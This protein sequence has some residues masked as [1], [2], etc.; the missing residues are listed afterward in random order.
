MILMPCRRLAFSHC[1]DSFFASFFDEYLRWLS[2][3]FEAFHFF[4]FFFTLAGFRRH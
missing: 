3:I 4:S 2:W 1:A